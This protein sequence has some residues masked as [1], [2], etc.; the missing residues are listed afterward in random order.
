MPAYS[1]EHRV[2]HLLMKLRPDVRTK[3]LTYPEIPRTRVALIALTARFEQADTSRVWEGSAREG[4]QQSQPDRPRK[5]PSSSS[6]ENWG[7]TRS[8]QKHPRLP[9][10]EEQRQKENNLCF[11]CGKEGHRAAQCFTQQTE[12]SSRPKC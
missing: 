6:N 2:Q 7:A 10:A 11:T 9:D 3:V 12:N 1:E 4:R 8:F 5:R